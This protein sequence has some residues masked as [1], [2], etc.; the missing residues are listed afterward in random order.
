MNRGFYEHGTENQ[1]QNQKAR[2]NSNI[3]KSFLL[4]QYRVFQSLENV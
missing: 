2:L 4:R 1:A 3:L